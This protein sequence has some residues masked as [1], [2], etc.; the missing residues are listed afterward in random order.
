MTNPDTQPESTENLNEDST[1]GIFRL[2]SLFS[3]PAMQQGTEDDSN[4]YF[5]INGFQALTP[6]ELNTI[7]RQ[8]FLA[9]KIVEKYPM[10]AKT[11]G[12]K[13]ENQNG[14]II[15]NGD[16]LLTEAIYEAT[17]WARLYG[18]SFLV[19]NYEK[20]LPNEPL[21]PKEKLISYTIEL[22][23]FKEGDYFKKSDDIIYHNSKIQVFFGRK[24]YVPYITPFDEGYAD[25]VLQSVVTTLKNYVSSNETARKI[26]SNISYLLLGIKN[27]GNMTKTDRGSGEIQAR[28]TSI[29]VNRNV[30]RVIA[31]DKENEIL[32]YISQATTGINDLIGVIK[33]IFIAESD[34]PASELF[35]ENSRQNL[36]SGIA[37]QLIARFLWTKRCHSYTLREFLPQYETFYNRHYKEENYKVIIPFNLELSQIE[38]AELEKFASERTKNLI[39]SGVISPEEA[40]SGYQ[41]EGFN[42]NIILDD[43]LYKQMAKTSKTDDKVINEK[44]SESSNVDSV[45]MPDDGVWD[46]YASIT[47]DDL[48]DVMVGAISVSK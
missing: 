14:E 9:R 34:Y 43:N 30:N 23:I 44:P 25:S 33:E 29:K 11:F 7:F 26:L 5:S 12:Y 15:E 46:S 28:L 36:G 35:E 37:N 1:I 31:Y 41:L 21:I 42:L 18:R 2:M 38:Q 45:L 4:S 16:K 48:Y 47:D 17:I 40:R 13:L 27:L 22:E 6:I 39:E 3:N 32:S 8:S 19:L 10:E 20:S 24:T